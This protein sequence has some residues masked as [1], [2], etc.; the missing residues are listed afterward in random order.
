MGNHALLHQHMY[1]RILRNK[2]VGGNH[3]IVQNTESL[4]IARAC[5]L[6]A[7][8][9]LPTLH[10][11]S[12]YDNG[13]VIHYSTLPVIKLA[14]KCVSGNSPV[15]HGVQYLLHYTPILAAAS[16][17]YQRLHSLTARQFLRE[18]IGH[19]YFAL[20]H[21]RNVIA[22][23]V[24]RQIIHLLDL[25]PVGTIV[26]AGTVLAVSG[27]EYIPVIVLIPDKDDHIGNLGRITLGLHFADIYCIRQQ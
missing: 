11:V 21:R 27:I 8:G 19:V 18:I 14:L 16:G 1:T 5:I 24:R 15:R 3:V 25:L 12:L 22:E 6:F 13:Q 9:R 23:R 2:L 4:Q 7:D 17:K 20:R 26:N 10:C